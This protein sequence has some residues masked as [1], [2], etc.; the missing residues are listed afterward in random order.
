[1]AGISYIIQN[2]VIVK[3][4]LNLHQSRKLFGIIHNLYKVYGHL[5][6]WY[7]N[8]LDQFYLAFP[9]LVM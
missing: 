9:N 2:D 7:K 6:K 1:M 3:N 5:S 4:I 8:F